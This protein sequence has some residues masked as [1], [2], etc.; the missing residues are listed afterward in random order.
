MYEAAPGLG[1]PAAL[2]PAKS[3]P[4]EVIRRAQLHRAPP[5][6]ESR[7][8]VL[9]LHHSGL[10]CVL[11]HSYRMWHYGDREGFSVEALFLSRDV[12]RMGYTDSLDRWANPP[13]NLTGDS[14]LRGNPII[15]IRWRS[16]VTLTH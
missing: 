5:A 12:P 1:D 11:D 9:P 14:H 16:T 10:P 15:T 7:R 2:H 8:L 3:Q 6:R 4:G 13:E